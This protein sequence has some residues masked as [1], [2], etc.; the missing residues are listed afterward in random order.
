MEDN[1]TPAAVLKVRKHA[2]NGAK[3][4]ND[5]MGIEE[6]GDKCML[7][8]YIQ[9]RRLYERGVDEL[10]IAVGIKITG[11]DEES[12]RSRKL[13]E[14][15]K[16]NMEN[17]E[18]RIAT[19]TVKIAEEEV[20]LQ[21]EKENKRPVKPP[22]K[23]LT[24]PGNRK[25]PTATTTSYRKV[26]STTVNSTSKKVGAKS[27][28]GTQKKTTTTTDTREEHKKKVS[29]LKNVD[30]K[31]VELILNEVVEH[32]GSISFDNIGGMELPKSLLT[33]MVILP[34]ERPELFDGLRSPAR[35]LLLFGPPGNGKTLLAKALANEAKANF[36][37]IS[38][39][40]LT[41]RWVGEGEKLVRALFAVARE[42]QPSII[43]ID[44]ID[45]MLC[46]RR[47]NEHE[48]SRRMKTE[49][50]TAF[51][52]M[53]SEEGERILVLGAT[54]VPWELDTAALRRLT[55]RVYVPLPDV[56]TRKDILK[57]I[58]MKQENNIGDQEYDKISRVTEGYSGS[59][60]A[61]LASDAAQQP[62]RDLTREELK[63]IPKDKVRPV[64]ANDFFQA[65]HEI[66]K[67]VS[68]DHLVRFVEWNKEF[69]TLGS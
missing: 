23:I 41:S 65:M 6:K 14:K 37:N 40:T 9:A 50:L 19:L 28:T 53:S 36:F 35:G 69:G 26:P 55:K 34:S 21:K 43:F 49:F 48:A 15:M 63:S 46:S 59:D 54:N 5:A 16:P 57:K 8:D 62:I 44:E 67:S 12:E 18:A 38:A 10:K 3:Y 66:T 24:T 64:N 58:M 61:A 45:S 56:K 1:A 68:S 22:S 30:K 31:H 51:D 13:Q 32:G 4:I 20:N 7:P 25:P 27:S 42:L 2:K 39:A 33:E 11:A 17:A 47:E 60:L 29:H 52:G